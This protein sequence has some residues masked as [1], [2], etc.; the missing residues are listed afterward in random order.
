MNS[1]VVHAIDRINN[2]TEEFFRKNYLE[3]SRPVIITNLDP[4]PAQCKWDF[5]YMSR[6]AGDCMVPVYDWGEEGPT[7]EDKF[8][9]RQMKLS[10]AIEYARTVTHAK[11]QRYSVCQ[12]P[13]ELLPELNA[14]YEQINVIRSSEKLDKLPFGFREQRRRA[15]FI[16][17]F[18]G[19]HWHNGR[20]AISQMCCGRK[21][22]TLYSPK[23]SKYLY[24]RQL[25][26][27]GLSWWDETEAVFCSEIPFENGVEN[28]D[29]K[30]FPLY[31]RATPIEVELQAGEALYIPSH[32]WHFTTAV[33]PCVLMVEFWDAPFRRWG[34]PIAR[35]SMLMKPYRRFFY[36]RLIRLKKFARREAVLQS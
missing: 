24:P 1:Q 31:E 21:K 15:L 13:L 12:M 20:D 34:F 5:D 6:V 32:W 26:K 18:R 27:S 9:I 3:Q 16:S 33:E 7:I 17:F 29:R 25:L 36:Y 14:E 30:R 8:I 11:T 35:R 4:K 28:I 10:Q 23:D 2:P 22:F 19:I